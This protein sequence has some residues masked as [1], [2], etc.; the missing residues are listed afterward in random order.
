MLWDVPGVS[1]HQ[2]SCL[3]QFL[4]APS[5]PCGGVEWETGKAL[6]LIS[7][8][9]QYKGIFVIQIFQHKSKTAPYPA[10]VEK[11]VVLSQLKPAQWPRNYCSKYILCCCGNQGSLFWRSLRADPIALY[12]DWCCQCRYLGVQLHCELQVELWGLRQEA[13]NTWASA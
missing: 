5:P 10:N 9:Q 2:L 4:R 1:W 12:G 3:C 11:K 6:T 7:A 8:A 13:M